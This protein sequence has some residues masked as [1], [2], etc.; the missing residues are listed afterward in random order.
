MPGPWPN[1]CRSM[2]WMELVASLVR[3]VAWPAAIV[4]ACWLL[5]AKLGELLPRIKRGKLG[6]TG[7][8]WELFDRGRE[9]SVSLEHEGAKLENELKAAQAEAASMDSLGTPVQEANAAKDY[10]LDGAERAVLERLTASRPDDLLASDRVLESDEFARFVARHP[11]SAVLSRIREMEET[12]G[13]TVER[14]TGI[15]DLPPGPW[16]LIGRELGLVS[17]EDDRALEWLDLVRN[18]VSH[19]RLRVDT[20]LAID[21][22]R[23]A[24]QVERNVL[25]KFILAMQRLRKKR[26]SSPSED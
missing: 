13:D 18:E 24:E 23:L 12:L 21:V 8:E 16:R 1:L 20:D 25:I 14:T 3:S 19:G 22:G 4:A 10:G 15:A 7:F 6:T 11:N 26:P 9:L 2:N 5:R 17:A